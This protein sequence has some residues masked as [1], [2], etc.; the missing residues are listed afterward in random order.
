MGA[1]QQLL[2][3]LERRCPSPERIEA[4]EIQQLLVRFDSGERHPIE[5][6]QQHEHDQ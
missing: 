4:L 1:K 3:V 2:D 6:E 5:W